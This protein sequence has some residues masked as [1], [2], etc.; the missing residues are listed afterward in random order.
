MPQ[1]WTLAVCGRYYC[2]VIPLGQ[3]P[4]HFLH[5]QEQLGYYA[6][7]CITHSSASLLPAP[8]KAETTLVPA[9]WADPTAASY[10]QRITLSKEEQVSTWR[11]QHVAAWLSRD[12]LATDPQGKVLT[13]AGHSYFGQDAEDS[14]SARLM[15]ETWGS[16]TRKQYGSDCFG[17]WLQNLDSFI[18]GKISA[19]PL[20]VPLPSESCLGFLVIC[21]PDAVSGNSQLQGHL[22][23][24]Y[25]CC[26][27][28]GGLSTQLSRVCGGFRQQSL[29]SVDDFHT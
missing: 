2:Y 11:L 22:S 21:I 7:D 8:S 1:H 26:V 24:W 9:V 3:A 5:E 15:K 4:Q 19:V 25:D 16:V 18:N 13:A 28:R 20:E 6:T 14:Q 23:D 12:E 29:Y 27:V 17:A 10:H